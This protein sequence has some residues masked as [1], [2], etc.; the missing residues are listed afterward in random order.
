[1]A[2][3]VPCA[4]ETKLQSVLY[5]SERCTYLTFDH[6]ANDRL[7]SRRS[8][9]FLYISIHNTLFISSFSHVFWVDASSHESITMSLKGISSI[10]DRQ[11]SDVNGSVESTL[12]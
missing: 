6:C 9:L 12:L 1:M 5:W 8:C 3:E 10:P 7:T 11:V 4:S 2:C